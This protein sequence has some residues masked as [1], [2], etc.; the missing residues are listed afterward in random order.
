MPSRSVCAP[1]TMMASSRAAV[2]FPV[3]AKM[4]AAKEKKHAEIRA[5]ARAAAPYR[6]KIGALRE[7][8]VDAWVEAGFP[9]NRSNG[10]R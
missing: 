2:V 7:E 1:R 4:R 8:D 9:V 10:R 6:V 5:L 3:G